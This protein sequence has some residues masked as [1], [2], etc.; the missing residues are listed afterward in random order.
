MAH[1][2]LTPKRSAAAQSLQM[3]TDTSNEFW[4]HKV[5]NVMSSELNAQK[6]AHHKILHFEASPDEVAQ[7]KN[8]L[9]PNFHIE[10]KIKHVH[11]HEPPQQQ[12]LKSPPKATAQPPAG[13]NAVQVHVVGEPGATQPE[14]IYGASVTAV[15]VQ[16]GKLPTTKTKQTDQTGRTNFVLTEATMQVGM[17]TCA[18][19]GVY[20]SMGDATVETT[21]EINCPALGDDGPFGW[22][23]QLMGVTTYDES[24]G[25][26]MR[27]GV[28]D[29]GMGPNPCLDN[30]INLGSIIDGIHDSEGGADID[31]H[32]SAICGLIGAQ[33]KKSGQYAGMSPGA[34]IYSLRVFPEGD[35]N[36]NQ[37]DIASAIRMLVDEYQ[38]HLINLSLTA[39]APSAIEHDAIQYAYEKGVVCIC[40]SGNS[41]TTVAY[42]AA[43]PETIAVGALGLTTWGPPNSITQIMVPPDPTRISAQGYYVPN[44][45]NSGDALDCVSP[46]V[47]L[48]STFPDRYGLTEAYGDLAGTSL[49]TPMVVSL[50]CI[51]LENDETYQAMT[52]DASRCEYVRATLRKI[53]SSLNLPKELEGNGVPIIR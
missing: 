42:P 33:P 17:I 39:S 52:P 1:F 28:A 19:A 23:Q 36:A 38:V 31:I 48:I 41:G 9:D 22:W 37:G 24:R 34:T 14:A 4:Q 45:S 10:P 30:I 7:Q 50:L 46:A 49:A 43:F 2:I 12:L 53:C 6:T 26:G 51:L 27:V 18:P 47:G 32:G 5:H 44:F 40:A 8:K 11:W 16:E 15:L 29:T 3:A 13:A 21:C 25:K 20:W 35:G